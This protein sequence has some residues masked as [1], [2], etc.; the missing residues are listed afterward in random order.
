MFF[1]MRL[2]YSIFAVFG[3][4]L[5]LNFAVWA[6]DSRGIDAVRNK[7]VL[8]S[9][10]LKV[11]ENFIS[12]AIDELVSTDDFASIADIRALILSKKGE[13]SQ[14]AEQFSESCY[15]N[16]YASL[17]SFSSQSKDEYRYETVVN[18]MILL[19][20]LEDVRLM[21]L[22]IDMLKDET[23]AVRYWAVH[24]ITN[25]VVV[26]QLVSAKTGDKKLLHRIAGELKVVVDGGNI[27]KLSMVLEFCS[28][29]GVAEGDELLSH[30]VDKRMREYADWT[31]EYELLDGK[32]LKLLSGKISSDDKVNIVAA[33]RF[34]QL[35]SYVLQ[36]YIKGREFLSDEQ[37]QQL[38]SVLVEVEKSC[39]SELLGIPQSVIKKAIEGGS[40]AGLL[41]EHSRLLGDVTR[42]G[43]LGMKFD[44]D[45]GT[46]V[47]GGKLIEPVALSELPVD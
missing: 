19:D 12:D 32:I 39:I 20:G 22:A 8:D 42:P 14:Y 3:M 25:P 21:D 1:K 5:L 17:K 10:D 34:S 2:K 37:K 23:A 40:Y 35:Y 15:K 26:E 6:V 9:S 45:Y 38:A 47:G 29:V 44:F 4:V 18:L 43:E 46:R 33:R 27:D 24:S 16:L 36:R 31:V 11:I 13:Q 7:G 28:S 41:H 30:I